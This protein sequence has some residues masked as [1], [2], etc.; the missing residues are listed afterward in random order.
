MI[1]A[2]LSVFICISIILNYIAKK[3]FFESATNHIPFL[4]HQSVNLSE[5][6]LMIFDGFLDPL[7]IFFFKNANKLKILFVPV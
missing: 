1:D 3:L 4:F 5:N 6:F 2:E 7:T